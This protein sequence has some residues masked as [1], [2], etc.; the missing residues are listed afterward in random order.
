MKDVNVYR[1]PMA[2][3]D[4]VSE[5]RKLID[6]GTIDPQDICAIKAQ[7]EGDAYSRGYGALC[8]ELLLA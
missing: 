6:D 7:T 1:L 3:P 4:D 2:S 8:F 5:L